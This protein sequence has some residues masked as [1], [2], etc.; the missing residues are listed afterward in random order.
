MSCFVIASRMRSGSHML[1]SALDMHPQIEGHGEL[2]AGVTGS[3][4]MPFETV[5]EENSCHHGCLLCC[6]LHVYHVVERHGIVLAHDLYARHLN[7]IILYRQTLLEQYVSLCDA[8]W[9]GIWAE[10]RP[11]PAP[12][13]T[14]DI[15]W[16][17]AHSHATEKS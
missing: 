6:T 1:L 16:I 5:K 12:P 10:P 3:L 15:N 2:F 14:I 9:T 11:H 8:T 4:A 17:M 7:V 13:V